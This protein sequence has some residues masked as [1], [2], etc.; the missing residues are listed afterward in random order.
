MP[1]RGSI[2]PQS[3]K[4]LTKEQ[5]ALL[6]AAPREAKATRDAHLLAAMYY[7]GLRDAEVASLRP[8]HLVHVAQGSVY[9][10]TVKRRRHTCSSRCA[11]PCVRRGTWDRRRHRVIDEVLDRPLIEV[12]LVGGMKELKALRAWAGDRDWVFPGGRR[13]RHLSVR[14]VQRVFRTWADDVGLEAEVTAH[15]LRHSSISALIERG[16][17][18]SLVRD[19]ARHSNLSVTDVYVHTSMEAWRKL[20][21]ALDLGD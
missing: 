1:P 11:K 21:D 4:F 7:L 17:P 14:T 18:P 9:V 19:F 15:S 3:A 2:K 8:T 12:R 5:V 6:L 13:G 10:P 16:A 20:A